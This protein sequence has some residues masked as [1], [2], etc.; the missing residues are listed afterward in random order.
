MNQHNLSQRFTCCHS[1]MCFGSLFDGQRLCDD[2]RYSVSRDHFQDVPLVLCAGVHHSTADNMHPLEP[3]LLR[4]DG[5]LL[6]AKVADK[7][8]TP[9]WRT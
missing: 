7:D 5:S 3:A 1:P 9:I 6:S 4:I 2:G 8:D